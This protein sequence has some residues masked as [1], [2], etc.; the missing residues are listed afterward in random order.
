MTPIALRPFAVVNRGNCSTRALICVPISPPL[1]E[2][3]RT[4]SRLLTVTLP[5]SVGLPAWLIEPRTR[6]K[7]IRRIIWPNSSSQGCARG[8]G[9]RNSRGVE[10]ADGRGRC[11]VPLVSRL[12]SAPDPERV[13][14]SCGVL[15]SKFASIRRFTA[16]ASHPEFLLTTTIVSA[17]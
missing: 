10:I 15:T 16:V 1:A 13:S 2:V 8:P 3:W 4:L 11:A 14:Q 5:P 6:S 9:Y 7:R 17:S 12:V